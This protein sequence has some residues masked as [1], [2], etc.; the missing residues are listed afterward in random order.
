[1]R[2]SPD[3]ALPSTGRSA[4]QYR[5]LCDFLPWG[6]LI[7]DE[8]ARITEIN[9]AAASLIGSAATDLLGARL[10]ARLSDTYVGLLLDSLAQTQRTKQRAESHLEFLG[11]D[12]HI[13]HVKLYAQWFDNG[14]KPHYRVA[15]L[16][17]T[18]TRSSHLALRLIADEMRD[19][20]QNAPCGYHSLDADAVV[21]RINDTELRW[22]GYRRDEVVRKLTL[23]DLMPRD[24]HS[25]FGRVFAV[26]KQQGWVRDVQLEMCR[27]DGSTFPALL[28]ATVLSDSDGQFLMSRASIFDI[29]RRRLAEDEASRYAQQ[30]R[31]MSRRAVEIQ[32]AE[33]R[34]LAQE[35][36]DRVGQNL[37][38]LNINLNIIKGQI[39]P[40]QAPM[41]GP[42]LDDSL[43]LVEAT[44]E[45]IRDVMA[46][47]RP[48]VL[49][50]YGLAAVLRWYADD[51]G[52]RTGVATSVVG[53]DPTPRLSPAAEAIL[54]RIAQESLINVAKHAQA[55]RASVALET[56]NG[57]FA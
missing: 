6:H 12:G 2:S 10:Q 25:D 17:V 52:R 1:M 31:A 54:F 37:T 36:H 34:R 49:D 7:L 55:R 38:V 47:L 57:C 41:V 56:S 42:R 40:L 8:S 21:V 48:A 18:D 14:G 33:R 9:P 15:L 3:P 30:L 32:E 27:K 24:C 46:E 11:R 44:V 29:T 5:E 16:D 35:L 4:A 13:R 23:M 53:H 20:Y 22:L 43:E 45:S 28:S 26:L 50:D 51:F 39:S 19:L